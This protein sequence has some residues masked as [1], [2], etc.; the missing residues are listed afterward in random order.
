[1]SLFLLSV[2]SLHRT[3]N[4]VN[5]ARVHTHGAPGTRYTHIHMA[6]GAQSSLS[7]VPVHEGE[8]GGQGQGGQAGQ[9]G[10]GGGE[11]GQIPAQAM[12]VKTM[13]EWTV[14]CMDCAH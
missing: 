14:C 5:R 8:G 10:Q 9:G 11:G 1:M 12:P 4:W 2:R 13:S 6:P 7:T 3:H